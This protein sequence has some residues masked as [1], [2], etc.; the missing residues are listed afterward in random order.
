MYSLE[1]RKQLDDKFRKLMERI[2][3]KIKEICAEP[4]H[5]KPLKKP[6]EGFRRVHIDLFVL[7]FS[8]DEQNKVVILEQFEHHDDAY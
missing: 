3:K 2:A 7:I 5:F 8:V 6:L 1:I 4:K